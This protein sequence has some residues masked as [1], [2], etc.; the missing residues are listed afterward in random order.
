M[1]LTL[2]VVLHESEVNILHPVL[3]PLLIGS[4]WNQTGRIFQLEQDK[5]DPGGERV[6][7]RNQE[8]KLGEG[9][10]RKIQKEDP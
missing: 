7:K 4:G 9:T 2:F 6:K 3:L 10:R 8:D 5:D 1:I